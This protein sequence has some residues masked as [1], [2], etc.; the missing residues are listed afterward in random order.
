MA[1]NVSDACCVVCILPHC[2]YEWNYIAYFFLF[3]FDFFK[4]VLNLKQ[5]C[6]NLILAMFV[7]FK[8]DA[9]SLKLKSVEM[10]S[11]RILSHGMFGNQVF[12]CI[13]S[14]KFSH[15]VPLVS[16]EVFCLSLQLIWSEH[17][18]SSIENI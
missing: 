4:I 16:S 6:P 15:P 11:L 1:A 12:L 18:V 13:C 3:I 9:L 17:V 8:H 14:L 10:L 7:H 2:F 5:I